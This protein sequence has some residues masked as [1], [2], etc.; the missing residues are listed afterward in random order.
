MIVQERT[1]LMISNKLYRYQKIRYFM[2]ARS[3]EFELEDIYQPNVY[4]DYLFE[5]GFDISNQLFKN[6]SIKWSVRLENIGATM[7]RNLSSED[8]DNIN[9]QGKQGFQG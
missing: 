6:K 5:H 3:G 2:R 1:L 7:G 4:K 8:E 9:Y